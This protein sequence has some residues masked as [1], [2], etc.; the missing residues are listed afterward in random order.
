MSRVTD[1][2]KAPKRDLDALFKPRSVAVV[3]VSRR[4]ESL[5]RRALRH[6]QVHGFS[7]SLWVVHPTAEE[8]GGVRAFR[9]I[10]ELPETPDLVYVCTHGDVALDVVKDA[11]DASAPAV[12]VIATE[13]K[14]CEVPDDV[15]SLLA[16]SGTRLLGPN[17]PG[18]VSVRPPVAPHI[19]HFLTQNER[20]I[21]APIGLITQSGAIGGVIADHLLEVRVGFDWLLCTGNEYDVKLGEALEFL[22][23]Q[24][25]RSIGLFVEAVRDLESFRR[26]LQ[27]A[28]QNGIRVCAVKV[29]QSAAGERQA[30][31][32]T[33][34]L[35][36]S[37]VLFEQE[38]VR[39]GGTLC[40][41]LEELAAFVSIATLPAP[42]SRSVAVASSSGGMAGLV[43]DRLV[44]AGM[45][46]PELEDLENPW[47]TNKIV[48]D[49]PAWVVQRF[50]QML[51]APA[52][53]AGVF[54]FPAMPDTIMHQVTGA[55]A[56]TE[57]AKPYV[58]IPAAGMPLSAMDQLRGRAIATTHLQPAVAALEWWTRGA[59]PLEPFTANTTPI[60]IAVDEARAK[61]QLRSGG[62]AV[63]R[64]AVVRSAEEAARFVATGP[65]PYVVKCLRPAFAHKAAAGAVRLGVAADDRAIGEAWDGIAS[66][67]LRA[68]GEPMT[69]V[70]VEDQVE[71][72][73][74][75]IISIGYDSQYG[76]FLTVG[77]GGSGVEDLL[78][79]AHRLLPVSAPDIEAALA[80]LQIRGL[81]RQAARVRGEAGVAPAELVSLISALI[82]LTGETPGTSVELNP[83]IV[84]LSAMPPVAVDCLIVSSDG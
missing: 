45:S 64:G 43:A 54:G 29:G 20:L 5:G 8:V 44:A 82:R 48:L 16:R 12:A 10:A 74:E 78:D 13:G 47:D 27:L 60:L 4:S 33:G 11:V 3:G 57:I 23:T 35:T 2:S 32:H 84:P 80:E 37:G 73:I 14:I 51:D 40:R 15:R 70:L 6:L 53:G 7:G 71:P 17:G 25:I 56:T 42:T 58:L 83:V 77:A 36:G 62:I 21:S 49:D 75:L 39:H 61:D 41:D 52:V 31:T 68:A 76:P 50:T 66:A 79:V 34:A 65:G 30:A 81:L 28:R 63:P 9:S 18:F 55:M 1:A 67:V 38:L 69:E 26:G 22:A 46:V 24:D 59:S 19:S 72:G